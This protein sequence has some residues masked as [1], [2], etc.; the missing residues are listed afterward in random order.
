[1][2]Y[3]SME[4]RTHARGNASAFLLCLCSYLRFNGATH[5]R[6]WKPE[7][8]A[9][10]KSSAHA[11]MEPRTHARGN[12]RYGHEAPVRGDASMEPRT[13]ARGNNLSLHQ[14]HVRS[15]GFNGAT[16][17]RAWKHLCRQAL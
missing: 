16:H 9:E 15:G 4:P 12:T 11:S 13:H 6:A 2:F 7:E 8:L 1:M 10:L 17:S 3:A 5:S 14:K